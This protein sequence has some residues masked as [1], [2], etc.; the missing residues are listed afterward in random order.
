LKRASG[1]RVRSSG[2]KSSE[3]SVPQFF[4][5]D[6][7]IDGS[8]TVIRGDDCHHLINVRRVKSGD[9]LRLRS[10]TG[11]GFTARVSEVTGSEISLVILEETAAGDGIVNISLYMALL[12]SGNFEFVLQKAVEVGVNRIVPVTSSRTVPDPMKKIDNKLERWSKIISGAAKQC[13][14][15]NMPVLDLPLTF[16]DALK[17]DDSVMKLIAHPG[18]VTELRDYLSSSKRP[19]SISLLVGP[20]GGFSESEIN[21]AS[22]RGWVPVNFGTTHLR[23]E[24]AAVILPSLVIYHWS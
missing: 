24:T 18:A 8:R 13:F 20:E 17:N 19:D 14:R 12:K 16:S 6:S 11:R 9:M 5:K 23:A 21:S 2:L 7:D 22:E 1:F 10:D 4:I 15:S 3:N